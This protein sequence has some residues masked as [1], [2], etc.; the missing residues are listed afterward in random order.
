MGPCEINKYLSINWFVYFKTSYFLYLF[1]KETFNNL[2]ETIDIAHRMCPTAY[3][4]IIGTKA[5]LR[6]D[7]CVSTAEAEVYL[8]VYII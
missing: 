2:T 7:G 3:L 6:T 1:Q 5:D 4:V 8:H